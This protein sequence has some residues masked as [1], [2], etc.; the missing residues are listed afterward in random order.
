LR[1]DL[2]ENRKNDK[3]IHFAAV[4][5]T[6]AGA[7]IGLY[8]LFKYALTI[9]LPFAVAFFIGLSVKKPAEYISEKTK[10]PRSVVGVFLTVLLLGLISC[11]TVFALDRLMNEASRLILSL[12]SEGGGEI[13][14]VLHEVFDYISN[15][16]SRLPVLRELRDVTGNDEFWSSVDT[17]V[18][19]MIRSA[20]KRLTAYIPE[21]IGKAAFALPSV[22]VGA[23]V[24]LIATFY[25]SSGVGS[26]QIS[27]ILPEKIKNKISDTS[28]K[29]KP[30]LLGWLRAYLTVMLLTFIEL[31]LGLS[32]LRV[33]YAFII[34]IVVALVDILPVL[35]TGTVLLPWAAVSF[36]TKN[37]FLGIGLIILYA[38]VTLVHETV[39]PRL[40]G[41]SIGVPP[42]VTLIAM[43]AGLK[44]F[45]FLGMIAAPAVAVLLKAA[46]GSKGSIG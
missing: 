6:V 44:L 10:I 28:R 16:S 39:E 38:V 46:F 7:A 2:T 11:L 33:K 34:A 43:Y 15:I 19:E 4:T 5:V 36:I 40:V 22:F 41:K 21:F 18:V 42:L 17:S 8:L 24:T 20:A 12:S 23:V 9:I 35:G 13:G 37:Y 45:G 25:F 1:G 30:A 27:G 3:F 26:A 14:R 31:F 29:M 32:V